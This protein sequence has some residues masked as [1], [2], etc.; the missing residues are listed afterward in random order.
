M[1]GNIRRIHYPSVG[2]TDAETRLTR[3]IWRFVGGGS[4]HYHNVAIMIELHLP[5]IQ[6]AARSG[7]IG[8]SAELHH[9]HRVVIGIDGVDVAHIM[10]VGAKAI[11]TK[12]VNLRVV[13][14]CIR[15]AERC[16]VVTGSRHRG[17]Q[18][19]V[20]VG[21][22]GKLGVTILTVRETESQILYGGNS[23]VARTG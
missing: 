7:V 15:R 3:H 18:T 1:G 21:I 13:V 12:E 4:V 8:A 23:V 2:R 22:D 16:S 9:S 14:V 10:V 5:S 11:A 19:Q 6:I 20:A 17:T